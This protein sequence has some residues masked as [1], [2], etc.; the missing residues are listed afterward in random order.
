MANNLPDK[1]SRDA[2]I[3]IVDDEKA[4]I[5]ALTKILQNAGYKNCVAIT[6]ATEA[7]QRFLQI[8]PDL[9]LLDLHMEPLSGLDVLEQINAVMDPPSRPPV[10]VLTADTSAQGKHDALAAGATDFLAKPLDPIEIIL[11]VEHLL[12]GRALFRQ[13]QLYSRGLERLVD[14]RTGEVQR[15]TTDLEKAIAELRETQQQVIQQERMRALGTMA[16]GIAHDLNNGLTL[17][18]GYGDMLLADEVKFPDGSPER[19]CLQEVVRAGHD[20]AELVKRLRAFYRPSD[21]REPREA[22]NLNDLI[23]QVINMTAPRW[24]AVAN[25][26]GATIRIKKNL[27]DIATIAAAPAEL[28]DMLTNLIFNAVDAMPNGGRLCFRTRGKRKQVRLEISDT[29]TGMTEEVRRRCLEPF[30][31]TKGERG[32]GLGLAVS[33]GIIRRHGGSISLDTHLGKGTTF[34]IDLPVPKEAIEPTILL[35]RTSVSPLRILV[36]D[37]HPGICEIVAAY[38]AEDRHLVTTAGDAREALEKFRT[39]QFDLV[40]TDR[41]MPDISG[42]A[43]AASIKQLKPR[44]PVIMLTGFADLVNE[45]GQRSKNVNLV[46]SKPARLDDLRRAI[47]EVMPVAERA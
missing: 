14:Q 7:V 13:C 32:S 41:A 19:D 25:A 9:V 36:V 15:R 27:G 17:I 30:F 18:L 45:T 38:L 11:R 12:T 16:S 2:R 28:R 37:D 35:P 46:L 24:Q 5:A 20:N 40:I 42:D 31:T 10:L 3:L 21:T 1:V 33:Y 26:K 23:E 34:M 8:N 6:C 4:N 47:L 29:G 43:L 39:D 22:V 44:E